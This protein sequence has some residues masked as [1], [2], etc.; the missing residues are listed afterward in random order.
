M[1]L[2]DGDPADSGDTWYRVLTDDRYLYADGTIHNRAFKG[3]NTIAP[4]PAGKNRKWSHEIS[5]RLLSLV[6]NIAKDAAAFCDEMNAQSG[7]RMKFAGVVYSPVP[8]IRT[9][10]QHVETDARYTPLDRDHAHSD[11]VFFNSS[12]ADKDMLIDWLQSTLKPLKPG[13]VATIKPP[14]PDKSD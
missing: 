6:A 12:D 10:L 9:K 11:V 14:P 2:S 5:G 3:K 13:E 1:S 8:P 4:P 7:G